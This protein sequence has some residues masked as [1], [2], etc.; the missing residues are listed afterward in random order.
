MAVNF[1]AHPRSIIVAK[2]RSEFNSL[3]TG[4]QA[5][6]GLTHAELLNIISIELSAV[7]AVA[8]TEERTPENA[9]KEKQ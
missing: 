9:N 2:A 1:V 8:I 4:L 3:V 7:A 5:K 6:H